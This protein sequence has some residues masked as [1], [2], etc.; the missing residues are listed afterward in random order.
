M[1]SPSGWGTSCS[2]TGLSTASFGIVANLSASWSYGGVSGGGPV[3]ALVEND[4]G[5]HVVGVVTP[6]HN[7]VI[8]RASTVGAVATLAEGLSAL[9]LPLPGV[10]G[11]AAESRMFASCWARLRALPF[12]RAMAMQVHQASE[13]RS[14]KQPAPGL[15]RAARPDD[16]SLVAGWIADFNDEALD[17]GVSDRAAA[18]RMAQD[19]VSH[20]GRSLYLWDDRQPVSMVATGY[21]SPSEPGLCRVHPPEH[22]RKGY[23]SSSVAALSRSLLAG[24]LTYCFHSPTSRTPRP[25]TS[26]ER[27]ATSRWPSSTTTASRSDR[28]AF[29]CPYPGP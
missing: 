1:S 6:P 26:T 25:T 11:P 27:S 13:I 8:S 24:G 14:P 23:A 12:G 5:V 19:L 15:L 29:V 20:Q 10:S 28:Q 22:R 4:A 18:M 3:L 17:E 16:V 9:K 2:P 21:P 7:L